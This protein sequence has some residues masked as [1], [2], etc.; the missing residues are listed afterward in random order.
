MRK[1]REALKTIANSMKNKKILWAVA[2][3]TNLWLQGMKIKPNDIDIITTKKG[4]YEIEKSLKKYEIEKVHYRESE[5][6]ASHYGKFIIK[7]IPVEVMGELR[8][9]YAYLD[10]LRSRIFIKV[11]KVKIPCFALEAEIKAYKRLG[12]IEKSES[13]KN[14]L[15]TLRK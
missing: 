7:N 1:F 8:Y 10:C 13:V 9:K 5:T 14:Y 15:K 2:G 11:N 6:L 12:R 4:A 3:S